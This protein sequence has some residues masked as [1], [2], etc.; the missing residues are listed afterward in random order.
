MLLI[1]GTCDMTTNG[2]SN[3]NDPHT[4][5]G[6]V[7]NYD[8]NPNNDDEIFDWIPLDASD[9]IDDEEQ[10]VIDSYKDDDKYFLEEGTDGKYRLQIRPSYW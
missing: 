1:G 6:N 3:D 9:G 4:P 2:G 5:G 7:V 8:P 10:K